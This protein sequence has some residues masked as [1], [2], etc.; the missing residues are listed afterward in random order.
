MKV[1]TKVVRFFDLVA[2]GKDDVPAEIGPGFWP[3]LRERLDKLPPK[4]RVITF[5]FNRYAGLAQTAA[6]PAH[7][8]MVVGHV[9]HRS[10]WPSAYNEETGTVSA[11]DVGDE[12]MSIAELTFIVDIPGTNMVAMLGTSRAA[13][14]SAIEAWL[15]GVTEAQVRGVSYEL[16]PVL[17]KS[18]MD[19]LARA[20]RVTKMTIKVPRGF[21]PDGLQETGQ[22]GSALAQAVAVTDGEMA[23][24]TTW[25][26]GRASGSHTL[27]TGLLGGLRGVVARGGADKV[28]AKLL[29]P[30]QD[31]KDRVEAVDFIKQRIGYPEKIQIDHDQN[32]SEESALR[33]MLS[34]INKFRRDV[35]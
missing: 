29:L 18:T 21:N 5:G 19:K 10:D 16:V 8:Y 24:E 14:L 9:R 33:A 11:L 6:V 31:G 1:V 26:L 25:S 20:T 27:Q 17:D 22:V 3:L 2:I 7:A 35:L 34:A 30:T 13:S 12:D 15:A 23:V 28:R 4:D 32:F